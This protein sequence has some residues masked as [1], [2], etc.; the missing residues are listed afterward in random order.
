MEERI[1]KLE[2]NMNLINMEF[3]NIKI[4]M[5]N[6]NNKLNEISTQGPKLD[7]L[8]NLIKSNNNNQNINNIKEKKK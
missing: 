4:K 1:F 7:E 5:D 3:N 2:S 8:L 6:I